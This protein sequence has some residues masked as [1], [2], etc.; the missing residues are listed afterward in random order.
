MYWKVSC[1]DDG[2]LA[3]PEK[4]D[5][6]FVLHRH[7]DNEGVHLDLR[8]EQHAFLSGWRIAGPSLDGTPWATVKAPHPLVWLDQ[9]GDAIRE[10][11]GL[12]SWIERGSTRAVL[13]LR[14]RKE[15][16]QV[17]F[18]RE[19]GFSADV[20]CAMR[21]ALA[22]CGGAAETAAHLITDGAAARA[23]AIARLC[24]LGHEL[25]GSAFDETVWR[26]TLRDLSLD[27]IHT[28]LRAFEVRFDAKYPPQ[29]VSRPENLPAMD[30]ILAGDGKRV[31]SARAIA[32]S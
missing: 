24:G 23:R 29:P 17:L 1:V 25:D 22:A 2:H 4:A 20:V 13:L 10:D 16:R 12:Y 19:E 5:G 18:E 21:E 28:H 7:H 32:C 9:D 14:G 31:A 3:T 11:A 26:H 30:A 15:T 8:L 6:R 27:A